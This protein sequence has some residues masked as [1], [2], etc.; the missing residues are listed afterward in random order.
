MQIGFPEGKHKDICELANVQ[1]GH[2]I[3]DCHFRMD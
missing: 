1:P 2:N 3:E